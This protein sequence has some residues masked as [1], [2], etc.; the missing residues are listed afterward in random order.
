MPREHYA[1]EE[2]I[3]AERNLEQA[4]FIIVSGEVSVLKGDRLISTLGNSDCFG[5]MGYLAKARGTATIVSRT[6]GSLIK[7]NATLMEK[8]STGCQLHFSKH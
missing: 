7:I 3:I 2:Q 6:E 4:F 8:T 5:E 1:L